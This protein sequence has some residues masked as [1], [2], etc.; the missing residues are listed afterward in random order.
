MMTCPIRTD[1]DA[2]IALIQKAALEAGADAAVP[3][4]HWAEGGKGAIELAKAVIE[5]CKEPNPFK[6]LY[7]LDLPIKD[8]ILTIAREF[9]GAKDVSYEASAEKQIETFTG[10]GFA[11]LPICMAKT[12]YSF[13]H[14][15]NVKGAPTGML[16]GLRFSIVVRRVEPFSVSL[17]VSRFRSAR[18]VCPL[19]LGSCTLSSG[20]CRCVA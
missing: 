3:S 7:D 15:P 18:S 11:H 12:Q 1:T 10:Q 13:S 5:A 20:R 8:K 14:D 9:Y 4:N 2:E 19:V 6:F 16:R 17:Q